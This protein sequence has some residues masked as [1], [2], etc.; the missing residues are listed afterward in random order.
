MSA[1]NAPTPTMWQRAKSGTK[2]FFSHALGYFPRGIALTGL[3]FAGSAILESLT[4]TPGSTGF[5]L[6]VAG[7]SNSELLSKSAAHLAFGSIISGVLGAGSEA[8]NCKCDG[9]S[10]V[11]P[12]IGGGKTVAGMGQQMAK[13]VGETCVTAAT[14]HV[15][16]GSGLP[17]GVAKTAIKT[18]GF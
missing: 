7:W 5:G 10:G 6:G 3:V 1:D 11:A 2:G 9:A 12:N 15:F 8:I 13:S 14:E 17:A 18:M 16:T 4:A